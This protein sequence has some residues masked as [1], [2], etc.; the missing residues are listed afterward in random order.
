VSFPIKNGDFPL[1]FVCL[2][3]GNIINGFPKSRP[4]LVC[5]P[6]GHQTIV[7][8]MMMILDLNALMKMIGSLLPQKMVH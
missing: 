1:F 7:G 3:E 4:K 8:I 5:E 6:Q 2:P